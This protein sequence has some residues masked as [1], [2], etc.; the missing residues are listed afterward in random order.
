MIATHGNYAKAPKRIKALKYISITIA[1]I[2]ATIYLLSLLLRIDAVQHRLGEHIANE[3]RNMY[4]IPVNIDG[5]RIRHLDEIILKGL[6]VTEPEGDTILFAKEGTAHISPLGIMKGE[7]QINTLHLAGP[8][9]RISRATSKA[10][11][12][13]QFIIDRLD[14]GQKSSNNNVSIR[15]NQFLAYDGKFRYDI[16]D[17]PGLTDVMDKN[18]IM[19]DSLCC[20]ISIRE[21]SKGKA[22]LTIR[23]VSGREKSGLVLKKFKAKANVTKEKCI[24]HNMEISLPS[25]LVT[26]RCLEISADSQTRPI[27]T[28]S[29]DIKSPGFLFADIRPILGDDY[30]ELPEVAFDITGSADCNEAVADINLTTADNGI[31]ISATTRI[32]SIYD[33]RKRKCSIHL[34]DGF[35]TSEG[36]DN[37]KPILKPEDIATIKKLG[38]YHITGEMHQTLSSFSCK[39]H[40][41]TQAG[42]IDANCF[43]DNGRYSIVA[44]GTEIK[45]GVITGI[46]KLSNCDIEA[47]INGDPHNWG[48]TTEIGGQ[49]TWLAA[50][51][52]TY[53]PIDITASIDKK[54]IKAHI[55]TNDP[56]LK[57]SM[58]LSYRPRMK[59]RINLNLKVDSIVPHKLNLQEKPGNTFSFTLNGNHNEFGNNKSL[60]TVKIDNFTINKDGDKKKIRNIYIC[61]DNSREQHML[62][63]NSDEIDCNIIGNFE[64]RTLPNSLNGIFA[65][66]LPG[67]NATEE[68][69]TGNNCIFRLDIRRTDILSGIFNIP[70]TISEPSAINGEL[71]DRTGQM[72]LKAMINNATIAGSKYNTIE[73]EG[74]SNRKKADMNLKAVIPAKKKNTE[75]EKGDDIFIGIGSILSNGSIASNVEWNSNHERQIK[76]KLRFDANFMEKEDGKIYFSGKIHPD[77]IIHNDSIWNISSSDIFGNS[78]RLVINGLSLY[79]DSQSLKIN[80]TAGKEKN[81]TLK[82]E[83]KNLELATIFNFIKFNALRF[84]G[85]ATGEAYVTSAMEEPDAKGLF[86]INRFRING[87]DMGSANAGIG[88]DNNSKSIIIDTEINGI[89]GTSRVNGFLSQANDTIELKIKANDLNVGFLNRYLRGFISNLKGACNGSV[90]LRGSWRDM[91]LYGALELDCTTRVNATNT[92]YTLENDTAWFSNGTIMFNNTR[93]KDPYGNSGVMRGAVNH[94]FLSHWTCDLSFE[95]KEKLLLYDTYDFSH[96]PFYGTFFASGKVGLNSNREGLFLKATLSNAPGSRIIY[97]S[98]ESGGVRDNSFITFTDSSKKHYNTADDETN[99]QGFL[100]RLNLDFM[101]EIND[102]LQL[103]AYTNL[104]TDDYIDL[105]GNGTIQAIYDEHEGFTMKGN[106]NLERGTY[107]FTIQDI[108]PKE[109]SIT[110]GSSLVFNGNPFNAALNLKTKYLVPSAYLSDLSTDVARRKSVKVNCLMDIGGTLQSP[111]LNFDL[112]LPE[113]NEEEKEILA[114]AI[115]TPEQKNMQFIYLIGIGKFYTYDYN[116]PQENSSTSSTAMESF[117]SNTLSNQLNNMLGHIIDSSNW[118]ISGNFSTSEK[119]WN[120]MEVEGMLA[121]RLLNNR[122][123]INGNLGYRENP[124]ASSNLVGDFEVQWLLN[125]KGTVSLKAY[126]KTNDRYFSKTNLTTQG[127][128]IILRHDFDSWLWWNKKKEEKKNN[129]LEKKPKGNDKNNKVPAGQ[130]K[131]ETFYII[132]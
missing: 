65:R 8:D 7:I 117:I 114:S 19:V 28:I 48:S 71:D 54:R 35:I 132:K 102:R 32:S 128:G 83:V 59:E 12:N 41:A 6:L 131:E 126:S 74:Y 107:K 17:E 91:D 122:L 25:S 16:L 52:Y 111:H 22:N 47:R 90:Y 127:A 9:I 55:T 84:N 38:N 72:N 2:G 89:S 120:S 40:L 53:A 93:L 86:E 60:T 11:L 1:V 96:L 130:E 62:I 76:G 34:K 67:K 97:N 21:L 20:N 78:E 42:N 123:L 116:T 56:N 118:D 94:K 87:N 50:N 80:G 115:N 113:G 3:I 77:R 33:S 99:E 112:E 26:S 4:G 119:G 95:V 105:Y 18:H 104:K 13:I 58:T 36:L 46:Q 49:I 82:I 103:K 30:L 27:P 109:F 24:L 100:S 108:F 14:S 101:L 64:Y 73:I 15:I 10:P 79:N 31:D 98:S 129:K 121:G 51:G 43:Y 5:V 37:L 70:V 92:T 45:A 57:G 125:P 106:L 69:L 61:D 68:E 110:K 124:I 75:G 88:W 85:D 23:S 63:V 44:K 29:G 39:A 81:D 66:H